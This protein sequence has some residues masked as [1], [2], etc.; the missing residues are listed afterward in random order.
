MA[1]KDKLTFHFSGDL[2][3][4]DTELATAMERLD[5]TNERVG[6]LLRAY[7]PPPPET[8]KAT[9]SASGGQVGAAPEAP[10]GGHPSESQRGEPS[11]S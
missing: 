9:D 8:T 4:V 3:A 2:E 5:E 1:K 7:S 6:E 11:T 10:P